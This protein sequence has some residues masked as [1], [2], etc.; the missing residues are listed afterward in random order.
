[1]NDDRIISIYPNTVGFGY[2]ILSHKGEI[3]D[4]GVVTVQPP[5]NNKCLIRISQII[6][7]YEPKI[8]IIEDPI[9]SNKAR[10]IKKLI[11][12]LC[13]LTK[14]K[15]TVYQYSKRQIR[16]TFEVFGAKHKFEISRKIS[17]MYPEL[18]T[19][20]PEKRKLWEPENYYQGIFDAMSLV[21]THLYL[22]D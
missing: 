9:K 11:I 2:V 3:L 22:T 15:M 13:D 6:A 17:E 8:L 16:D 7:Y 12:K 14:N 20:L 21:F 4:Y 1:M 5:E 18:K 10:R 19:K